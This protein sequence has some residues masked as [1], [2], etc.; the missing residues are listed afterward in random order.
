MFK[1][2]V[3]VLQADSKTPDRNLD[4]H[5]RMKNIRNFNFMGKHKDDFLIYLNVFKR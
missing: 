5:K 3:K 1:R 2:T 4:K